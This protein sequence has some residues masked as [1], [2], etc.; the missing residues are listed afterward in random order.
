MYAIEGSPG[1]GAPN[2]TGGSLIDGP[3]QWTSCHVRSP[4]DVAGSRPAEAYGTPDCRRKQPLAP[5]RAGGGGASTVA[6][7]VLAWRADSMAAGSP[8]GP[9]TAGPSRGPPSVALR[10]PAPRAEGVARRPATCGIPQ[11]VG[12]TRRR[13]LEVERRRKRRMKPT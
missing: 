6:S 13:W 4:G 10:V 1:T 5:V 11:E 3:G 2:A 7:S 12:R 9:V 8:M